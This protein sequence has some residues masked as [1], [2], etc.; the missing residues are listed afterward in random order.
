MTIEEEH[1][2]MRKTLKGILD[3]KERALEFSESDGGN[4]IPAAYKYALRVSRS[5]LEQLEEK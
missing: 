4:Y 2:M 1:E 5:A 3:S